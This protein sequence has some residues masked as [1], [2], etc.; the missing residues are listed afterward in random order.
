MDVGATGRSPLPRKDTKP[1]AF[2]SLGRPSCSRIGL[3]IGSEIIKMVQLGRSKAGL[4]LIEAAR[5][6]L[7]PGPAGGER[8]RDKEII[9]ALN[10]MIEKSTFKGREVI[11]T[12]SR[13]DVDIRPL[14]ITAESAE[15]VEKAVR[16]EAEAFL[17]YPASEAVID[18]IPIDELHGKSEKGARVLLVA[19][20]RERII[21]HLDLLKRTGLKCSVVDVSPVAL[22][23]V[24]RAQQP[25]GNFSSP[26]IV[27]EIGATSSMA[28]VMVDGAPAMSWGMQFGGR[29]ITK[30]IMRQL[31]LSFSKAESIKIRYGIVTEG[32]KALP[33]PSEDAQYEGVED[34]STEPESLDIAGVLM[35]IILPAMERLESE[36]KKLLTYCAAEIRGARADKL[37]LFGGGSLIKN[38]D[39]YLGM[40]TN[41]E[42]VVGDSFAFVAGDKTGNDQG[43]HRREGSAVFGVAAGLALRDLLN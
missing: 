4:T 14:I 28:I 24:L 21:K 39:R 43:L 19:V 29:E 8:N 2:F 7:P 36:L 10:E 31:N 15:E 23:R 37:I 27:L 30:A 22:T 26:F 6:A 11:S 20:H 41:M 3:D 25:E 16:W 40:I 17:P 34:E 1:M 32:A 35:D 5:R 12:V 42:V 13:S 9:E 38:L 18:Y 33:A